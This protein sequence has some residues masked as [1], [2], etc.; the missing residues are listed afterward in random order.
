[1]TRRQRLL[2]AYGPIGGLFVGAVAIRLWLN[3][4]IGAPQIL[5]DEFI[6]GDLAKNF[7]T[8]GHL[9]IRGESGFANPLY[10]V[11]ISPAWLVTH[12]TTTSF[13]IVKGVNTVVMSLAAFPIYFWTRR[14]VSQWWALFAA[15]LTLLLPAFLYTGMVMTENVGLPTFVL[16]A[17][18][19]SLVLERP[20]LRGQTLMFAAIGLAFFARTQAV[21]LIVILPT[22]FLL[23]VAFEVRAG[24]RG[25]AYLRTLVPYWPTAAVLALLAIGYALRGALSHVPLAST[26]TSYSA[27]SKAHYDHA[28]VEMWF[29]RHLTELE[30]AVAVVPFAVLILLFG[31]ALVRR[32]EDAGLR[33]FIA[34]AAAATFWI[35]VE[36]AIFAT[37]FTGF[38]TERYSFY[39]EPLLLA[40]FAVWLGRGMPRPLVPTVVAVAAPIVA[41]KAL[42]AHAFLIPNGSYN[43]ISLVSLYHLHFHIPGGFHGFTVAEYVGAAA[44]GLVL[45]IAPKKVARIVLPVA[46][47]AFLVYSARATFLD[48]RSTSVSWAGAVG[49]VRN[50]VDR[51]VGTT[52]GRTAVLYTQDPNQWDSSSVLM[53]TQFWNRTIGPV[54]NIAG[55]SELCPLPERRATINTHTG[56]I[57]FGDSAEPLAARTGPRRIRY[58]LAAANLDID[59]KPVRTG[60]SALKRWA[61]YPANGPLRLAAQTEGV[62]GDGWMGADAVYRRYA[63]PG[64]APGWVDVYLAR[65]GWS[66][67]DVPGHATIEVKRLA[68]E[69]AAS[70]PYSRRRWVVHRLSARTLRLPAPA[71]PFEVRV[72]ISPTFSPSQF[73]QTDTRQLGAQVS[74]SWSGPRRSGR[75][76]VK[77]SASSRTHSRFGLSPKLASAGD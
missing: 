1:M 26:F 72:R 66:G 28:L 75:E 14:L 53:Q 62:A 36:V 15:G 59:A 8:T 56:V 18:A 67:P 29:W 7:A 13:A 45:A 9:L 5:C 2:L 68:H 35:L 50:W 69:L 39:A 24:G 32:V 41:V 49:D 4:T 77:Q 63:T 27:V 61:I 37:Q 54:Y 3:R 74:F 22:A 25:R 10:A 76:G 51:S 52:P 46:V 30:L 73:G 60:G 71:P 31:L 16:A 42:S 6:Y 23:K 38:V 33:A 55:A 19:I 48:T 70:A 57:R 65:T 43:S 64:N 47:A 44:A 58:L 11:L 40:A 34:V 12:S 20:T 17:F 21:V